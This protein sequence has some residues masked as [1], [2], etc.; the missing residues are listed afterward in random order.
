MFK[1]FDFCKK[2]FFGTRNFKSNFLQRKYVST[3]YETS[4]IIKRPWNRMMIFVELLTSHNFLETTDEIQ[5]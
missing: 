1:L 2:M 3:G 5:S 4:R